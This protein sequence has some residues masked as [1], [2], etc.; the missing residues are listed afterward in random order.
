MLSKCMTWCAALVAVP[1]ASLA[2]LSCLSERTGME[3]HA[4]ASC[5]SLRLWQLLGRFPGTP[6]NKCPAGNSDVTAIEMCHVICAL[7]AA[8]GCHAPHAHLELSWRVRLHSPA[9]L[10]RKAPV[11]AQQTQAWTALVC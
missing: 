3:L 7:H 11:G 2:V 8:F 1:R 6:R 10:S 5:V 4:Q 9:D